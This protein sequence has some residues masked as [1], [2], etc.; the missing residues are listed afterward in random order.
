MEPASSYQHL[1]PILDASFD[2]GLLLDTENGTILHVNTA[3]RDFLGIRHP[4]HLVVTTALALYIGNEEE[5]SA[6]LSW[7]D[8]QSLHK[9]KFTVVCKGRTR[10][11]AESL[12]V[13][14]DGEARLAIVGAHSILWIRPQNEQECQLA[15]HVLAGILEA[16]LDP[17]FQVNEQGIIQ[18]VNQGCDPTIW[19]D[20]RRVSWKQH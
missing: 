5:S 14:S 11:V 7:D 20:T 2:A 1:L 16:A 4:E 10:V 8:V 6:P 3:A 19:M 9:M 12:V 13:C 15:P 17:L 18:M